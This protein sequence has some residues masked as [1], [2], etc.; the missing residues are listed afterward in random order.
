MDFITGALELAK[1]NFLVS[2]KQ[3]DYLHM[4]SV[5]TSHVTQNM[6]CNSPRLSRL[7]LPHAVEEGRPA[8]R[9]IVHDPCKKIPGRLLLRLLCAQESSFLIQS[10][11][12]ANLIMTV[13]A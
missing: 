11:Q 9:I 7:G 4:A 1:D 13:P 12:G 2:N 3:Y 10:A 6:L 8:M 5:W